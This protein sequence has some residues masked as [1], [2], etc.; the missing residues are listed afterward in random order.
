MTDLRGRFREVD[1][2]AVPDLEQALRRPG[3]TRQEI[4]PARRLLASSAALIMAMASF[5][6]A[7]I[8]FDG[9]VRR[10]VAPAESAITPIQRE[11]G[12]IFY[13]VGGEEGPGWIESVWPDGTERQIA[14]EDAGDG[15]AQI[16]WSPDG[17]RIAYSN[18]DPEQP[19]IYVVEADGS[20]RVQLTDGVNDGWPSWSPDGARIVFSSTRHDLSAEPCTS[21][22]DPDLVCQTDIYVMDSNGS[23][24]TH[25][26]TG[27]G[28]EYQPVWSP[29]GTTIAFTKAFETWI[30]TVVC[31]MNADGTEISQISSSDGGSDSSPSWSP[32]GSQ[33]AF[34]GFRYESTGIW[35]VGTDG[36]NELQILGED[37]YSVEHPVWSPDGTLIAFVGSPNGGEAALDDELYVMRPDGTGVTQLVAAPGN[38]V[39]GEV[40]WQPITRPAASRDPTPSPS[41]D[42]PALNPRVTATIPIGAFPHAIAVAEGAAWATV[43]NAGGGP[44]DHLLV[45]ID[46]ATNEIVE[47]IPIREAG[48]VA[49]GAGALWVISWDGENFGENVLLRIDPATGNVVATVR[50]GS[51]A[52]NVGFGF[53]S[54]WATV[55]NDGNPA[56]GQVLRIDPATNVVVARIPVAEGWPRDLV[57]GEGSVWVYGHS[58]LEEHGWVASSLWRIDPTTNE[59]AA[60]LDESGFLGDGSFLPDNVAVGEGWI[61]AADDRGNGVRIDAATGVLAT[62]RPRAGSEEPN[63]FAWP[64]AVYAG[65]VFFGLGTI[66][67]LD[68]ETFGVVGSIPLKSQ[69][70]DSALDP[71]TG[72]LWIANLRGHGHS[73]RPL[74]SS[75]SRPLRNRLNFHPVSSL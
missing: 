61:W 40:A 41:P 57:I 19:G 64:Y 31:V 13:R 21:S 48:D 67:V 29:D 44:N 33:I 27:P 50:L 68:T 51:I 7:V 75:R 36:S 18:A 22:G 11:N 23:N 20:G 28:A 16:A 43:D 30:A 69:V 74:G 56:A 63:G 59:V 39:T 53:D 66:K 49:Y 72:T 71:V 37:W 9:D 24:V 46:P 70:A 45:R 32:D 73:D 26:R 4:S 6:F 65:H 52:S 55:A 3:T 10:P 15:I 1:R 5:A 34:W 54:A 58:K 38:G 60:V 42:V 47:T 35:I 62:F 12:P 17:A 14:F 2:V 8:A 25:L